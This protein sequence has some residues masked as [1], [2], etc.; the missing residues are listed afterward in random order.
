MN[1]MQHPANSPYERYAEKSV[2]GLGK[3]KGMEHAIGGDFESMGQLQKAVL[4]QHGVKPNSSLLDLG[5]GSGRLANALK[6]MPELKYVGVDVVAAFLDHAK[7]LAG[8]AD[9]RFVKTN[10]LTIPADDSSLDCVCAF[11]VF[12]HL[13]HEQTYVYLQEIKRALKD[14]GRLIFSFL[15]FRVYAHWTVF[16]E[17]VRNIGNDVPLNQFMDCDGIRAWAAHLGLD[18]LI[19]NHGDEMYIELPDRIAKEDGTWYENRASLGQSLCVLQKRPRL[20][21]NH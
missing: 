7:E 14:S 11:S 3:Q 6:N 17:N 12:T 4:L 10:E 19:I 21:E 5:C 8:R 15:E 18:I 1:P 20:V 13:R 2:L 9:W 16:E